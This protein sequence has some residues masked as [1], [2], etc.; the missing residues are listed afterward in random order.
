MICEND[1]FLMW[2]FATEPDLQ[3]L[4]KVWTLVKDVPIIPYRQDDAV[5]QLVHTPTSTVVGHLYFD[6]A[7]EFLT[8]APSDIVA[9]VAEVERLR[10]AIKTHK[11][12]VVID[13]QPWDRDLWAVLDA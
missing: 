5:Y 7:A 1:L 3:G 12:R 6:I 8:K 2:N 4:S 9:L 10:G 11:R 13:P